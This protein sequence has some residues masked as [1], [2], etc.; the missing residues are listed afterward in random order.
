MCRGISIL[1]NR[2]R[3]ELYEQYELA[4]FLHRRGESAEEELWFDFADRSVSQV[5]L[6]VVHDGQLMIYEWG[7]RGGKSSKLPKTGWCKK[8]SLEAGKWRWLHPESVEIP[9]SFGLE[10]G[11]WFQVNEGIRGMLVRDEQ[12][13]PRVYMITEPA[14]HYY[15]VMTR[16]DR[17]PELVNQRI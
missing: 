11:I 9:C 7:N 5:L 17:M 1:K 13:K 2:L 14:S 12:S 3:Q 6:P 4:R 10:K 15:E 8:E 16:H